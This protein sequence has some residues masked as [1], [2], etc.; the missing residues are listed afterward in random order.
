VGGVV[1]MM[2][3]KGID[4]NNNFYLVVGKQFRTEKEYTISLYN[5]TYVL[6][7][8]FCFKLVLNFSHTKN[9]FLGK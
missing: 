4:L 8:F 7:L 5:L 6:L 1:K 9:T 3:Q 2:C